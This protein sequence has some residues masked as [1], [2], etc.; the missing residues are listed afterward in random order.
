M[1]K[2]EK[3]ETSKHEYTPPGMTKH[4]PIKIVQ[5]SAGICSGLYYVTL[6]YYY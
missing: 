6:Y 3:K 4:E 1:D 2:I 5:G